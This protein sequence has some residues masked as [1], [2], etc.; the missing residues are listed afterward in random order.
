ME[1]VMTHVSVDGREG[2]VEK[3]YFAG[4]VI[5]RSGE[6]DPLSLSARQGDSFLADFGSAISKKIC[7]D[8]QVSIWPHVD[9]WAQSARID[10]PIHTVDVDVL[11]PGRERYIVPDCPG[12][13]PGLLGDYSLA[14]EAR[15]FSP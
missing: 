4:L 6:A 10:N 8:S 7:P 1:Q 5:S 15:N 3:D 14:S 11:R 2:I 13:Y 9:V 12:L